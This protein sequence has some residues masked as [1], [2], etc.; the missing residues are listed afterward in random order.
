[1]RRAV[2]LSCLLFAC[3]E[4][5][6]SESMPSPRA[7]G[8]AG[9]G[10]ASSTTTD[11]GGAAD[12]SV[13]VSAGARPLPAVPFHT[14]G[15]WILDANDERIK[16][17]SVNWYGAESKDFVVAGLDKAP[18]ATIASQIRAAGF[19][20][21][22]LPWSNELVET[23]P[24]VAA[25]RVSANP[26]LAGKPAMEV[27]DAVISALAFEGLVVVIDNHVSK[28]EW[29]CTEQD[30][31]GLWFTPEY[32]ETKWLDDWRT[33]AKRYRNV[34]AV[35]GAELRNELRGMPDGRKPSWGGSDATL[36]WRAAAKRGGDAV[37]EEHPSLLV[38][39]DGL[40][41][42][43]DLTG[44]Y[45]KPI[46]LAVAN[47]LVWSP[48]DYAWFHPGLSSSAQ[49]ETDLGNK[50]GF[51]LVQDKPYT[52]PVWI[53]EFGI[54]HSPSEIASLWFTSFLDYLANADEDWAYW[55]LN[56]TQST[57]TTRTL[58]AEETFGVLDLSW[59]KPALSSHLAALQSKMPVTQKP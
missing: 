54:A 14:Q 16:L 34:P 1:V 49:L 44:A 40:E 58:G 21:V 26:S 10:D 7:N 50:W 38:M 13:D 39:I 56:G 28:A 5:G 15:R 59:T 52:A 47:R 57:G 31:N 45:D 6:A 43:T 48:H 19:N 55:A 22:R 53:S 4:S 29:C 24:P 17:A 2:V 11:S 36:D 51:L 37:L 23:N 30:G 32:P 35:V 12:A 42:S 46:S 20:S 8:D 9:D 3:A 27:F 33:M 41:Y 18:L 25:A